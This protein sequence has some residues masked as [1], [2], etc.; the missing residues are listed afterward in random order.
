[1]SK[2]APHLLAT[3]LLAS[4]LGGCHKIDAAMTD[5]AQVVAQ[6]TCPQGA[7]A[8]TPGPR[9]ATCEGGPTYQL[10][11][12]SWQEILD[13]QVTAALPLG[14]GP[15]PEGWI[16]ATAQGRLGQL[17]PGQPPALA[18][19]PPLEPP[20][21]TALYRWLL[22]G[23]PQAPPERVQGLY[24]IHDKQVLAVTAGRGAWVSPDQGKTWQVFDWNTRLGYLPGSRPLELRD[25]TVTR[26][27]KLAFLLYPEG[28]DIAREQATALLAQGKKDSTEGGPRLVTGHFFDQKLQ[29]RSIPLGEQEHMVP[30]AK[31]EG[32]LW[33]FIAH[34]QRHESTRFFSPD[35]AQTWLDNGYFDLTLE[36]ALGSWSRTAFVG[37]RDDDSQVL[38]MFQAQRRGNRYGYL[39]LPGQGPLRLSVDASEQ[40]QVLV[41]ARGDQAR[42]YAVDTLSE[43]LRLLW[44]YGPIALLFL[45]M[46]PLALRRMLQNRQS[47]QPTS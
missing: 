2:Y 9:L 21:G 31:E 32:G 10:Q 37:R 23:A 43:D 41:A 26:N 42:A 15:A 24:P 35:W 18:Q 28:Y 14:G 22:P 5:Q 12:Q 34:P 40:P 39:D 3:A 46:G 25:L 30:S 33:L 29:L 1:M 20:Q 45:L 44:Y 8:S 47:K 4:W 27:G 38:W 6:L 13:E 7:L 36:G 19:A 17:R 16:I 11:D